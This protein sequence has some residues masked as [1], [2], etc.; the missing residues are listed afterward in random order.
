MSN[1]YD[2][3]LHD[4]QDPYLYDH[5][6]ETAEPYEEGYED[7]YE[8]GYDDGCE[9][10]TEGHRHSGPLHALPPQPAANPNVSSCIVTVVLIVLMSLIGC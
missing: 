7:G 9:E 3:D 10:G 1:L 8:E 4:E 2:D 5:D 6:P